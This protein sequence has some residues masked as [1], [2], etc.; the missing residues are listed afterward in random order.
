M[1][2]DELEVTQPSTE[3]ENDPEVKC[4]ADANVLTKPVPGTTLK[5]LDDPSFE[6]ELKP[7]DT[8]ENANPSNQQPP[9]KK[10]AYRV[11]EG[12]LIASTYQHLI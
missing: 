10:P 7:K 12:T 8:L 1:L 2:Q 6:F 4:K 9:A 3:K 5:C 11:L